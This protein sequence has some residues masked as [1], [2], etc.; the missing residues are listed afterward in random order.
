MFLLS[1]VPL[2]SEQLEEGGDQSSLC[3][4]HHGDPLDDLTLGL[5]KFRSEVHLGGQFLKVSVL[6]FLVT[7]VTAVACFSS[8]PPSTN[9]REAE[10][11]SKVSAPSFSRSVVRFP[12]LVIRKQI[13]PDLSHAPRFPNN[14]TA[15]YLLVGSC[16]N[17]SLKRVACPDT[18]SANSRNLVDHHGFESGSVIILVHEAE[19]LGILAVVVAVAAGGWQQN[20]LEEL[21]TVVVGI[22]HG[23]H[24][25]GLGTPAT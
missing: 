7:R 8:S 13:Y 17:S 19:I 6:S 22:I 4:Q 11:V 21:I 16:R 14:S 25:N 2:D 24:S 23:S 3:R 9:T 10:R 1:Q 15:F 20:D 18:L 12:A 5:G